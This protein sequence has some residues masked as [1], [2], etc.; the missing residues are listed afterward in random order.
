MHD[1]SNISLSNFPLPK[2]KSNLVSTS[3]EPELKKVCSHHWR[4]GLVNIILNTN[5]ICRSKLKMISTY[6][7]RKK[8]RNVI[9][10]KFGLDRPSTM[11]QSLKK[12]Y[13]VFFMQN[14]FK[15]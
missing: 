10:H 3:I 1:N 15:K 7:K 9:K 6:S 11:T 5:Y 12:L 4:T 13:S 2:K 8:E 14:L